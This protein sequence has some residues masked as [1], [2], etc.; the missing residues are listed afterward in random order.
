MTTYDLSDALES[1]ED[2]AG[3]TCTIAGVEVPC[4]AGQPLARLQLQIGGFEP[5]HDLTIVVRDDA[6]EGLTVEPQTLLTYEASPYRVQ[7]IE[8][9]PGG[10]FRVLRCVS[11]YRGA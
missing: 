11:A 5:Q 9:P 10:G 7:E 6:I 8:T 1:I 3:A 4:L 2:E